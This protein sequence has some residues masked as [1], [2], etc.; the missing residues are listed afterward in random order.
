MC[1][2]RPGSPNH[3]VDCLKFSNHR[4]LSFSSI[5]TRVGL[6]VRFNALV[7]SRRYGGAPPKVGRRAKA[8][9]RRCIIVSQRF[10]RTHLNTHP[11][12]QELYG[13]G[14]VLKCK[15]SRTAAV[16]IGGIELAEKIKKGQFKTGGL[17]ETVSHHARNQWRA[18]LAA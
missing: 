12:R 8:T 6:I 2:H 16:V 17:G 3:A 18:A 11:S 4:K 15:T 14:R 13:M 9:D 1:T 10:S 7:A 5:G